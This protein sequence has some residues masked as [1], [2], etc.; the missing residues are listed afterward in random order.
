MVRR[1]RRDDVSYAQV[2][3]R[4]LAA[5]V[6]SQSGDQSEAVS[7]LRAAVELAQRYELPLCEA[8]ARLRLAALIGGHEATT[9]AR[10]ARA[11]MAA[12]KVAR[13]ERLL[14]VVAPGFGAA[15]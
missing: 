14:E 15:G 12:Q 10:P 4:L 2:W 11:W 7:H 1:L 8:C 9:V 5:G 13:P 3:S 6:A